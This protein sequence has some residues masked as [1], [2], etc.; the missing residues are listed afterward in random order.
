MHLMISCPLSVL[1]LFSE[2]VCLGHL[3][4]SCMCNRP[5]IIKAEVCVGIII[6]SDNCH[7]ITAA[8]TWLVYGKDRNFKTRVWLRRTVYSNFANSMLTTIPWHARICVKQC[9]PFSF[10][11]Q[12][13]H[14][15]MLTIHF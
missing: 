15:Q 12:P 5:P 8:E 6:V 10:H 2:I 14:F 4:H 7:D 11:Y 13:S 9:D 1:K 3:K